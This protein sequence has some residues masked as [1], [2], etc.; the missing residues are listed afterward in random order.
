MYQVPELKNYEWG[1]YPPLAIG[2][3]GAIHNRNASV[4]L[5]LARKFLENE[6][7]PISSNEQSS[8]P[9]TS[10]VTQN[11]VLP[12]AKTFILDKQEALGLRLCRW[13]GRAHII[14]KTPNL[15]FFLD[16]AHTSLSIQACRSWFEHVS[17]L[18][19][20]SI[21][22]VKTYKILI[23]NTTKDR[24]PKPLLSHFATFPF[25]K[26]IFSTNLTKL[27][28][29]KN[30]DNTNYTTSTTGQ[31]KRC[32]EHR[33]AWEELQK[34]KLLNN[35]YFQDN[36]EGSD[37]I[38]EN[39]AIPC[40]TSETINNAIDNATSTSQNDK[41]TTL[42]QILVTGSIHLVGGVLQIV[43]PDIFDRTEDEDCKR[44]SE[45]YNKLSAGPKIIGPQ[46]L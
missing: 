13:P 32:E 4:A 11:S 36:V 17:K 19:Q 31:S 3:Y 34:D 37:K 27:H 25:D 6:N 15:S 41:E 22:P 29:S 9:K 23:F 7:G 38:N 21:R 33:T 46:R 45:E 18:Q 39:L 35:G 8:G 14:N 2:L 26:V 42:V 20:E 24:Q 5:Q 10:S 1:N 43:D 44:I 30:S 16:G 28:S 12:T 40:Y